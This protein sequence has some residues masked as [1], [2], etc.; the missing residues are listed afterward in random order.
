MTSKRIRHEYH[1]AI[2]R[3]ARSTDERTIICAMLPNVGTDDTASI[4]VANASIHQECAL[5]ANL[6]SLVLDY[7]CAQ[8]IGGTDIRKHSFDQLPI[9]PPGRYSE[10]D[11]DF[12]ATRVLE[13]SYTIQS[14]SGFAHNLSYNGPP[15][16][17]NEDRR[18]LLRAELDAWYARAYGLSRDELRYILDPVDV[19]G[20]NYPSETFRV[21]K[22]KELRLYKEFRTQRLVLGAWDRMETGELQ[23]PDPFQLS[24][25]GTPPNTV[26]ASPRPLVTNQPSL[27]FAEPDTE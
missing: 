26:A 8:K 10:N 14:L 27:Q 21:L 15:F 9:F 18:A 3:I 2:R 22:E 25:P 12:I 7:A 16:P 11:L 6:N 23:Q 24:A 4:V 13:L 5:I 20:L 17:W 1:V 19:L